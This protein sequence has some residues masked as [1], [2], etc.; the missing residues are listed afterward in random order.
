MKR[1]LFFLLM[2]CCSAYSIGDTSIVALVGNYRI[3]AEDLL[4]SYEFGPS[5]V[6]R[7]HEPLR[8]HLTYMIYERLLALEAEA[9]GLQTSSFVQERV[10]ALEEDGAVEQLYRNDILSRVALTEDQIEQDIQ[11]AKIT[12]SLRW[13]FQPTKIEAD[14]C[15]KILAQGASF[16]SL[17]ALQLDSVTSI[18]SRSTEIS[19]LKLER[20]NEIVA[21]SISG[22]RV[23]ECT[24]PIQ[25]TDGYYII[26]LDQVRQNP[27]TTESEYTNLKKQ[28]VDIRTRII[29]DK[30]A[31]EYVKTMMSKHN[32]VIKA[33][34]F[35]I[36]RAYIASKGLSRDATVKWEIPTTFMTEAGPQPIQQSGEYLNKTLVTFGNRSLTIRDYIRWY[37]IRQFQFN[38]RSLVAFNSSVK[39]TIWKM[40]QDKLLSEEAYQRGLNHVP[41]VMHETDKWRVKLLYLA[42]RSALLRTINISDSV[43]LDYYKKHDKQYKKG[44]TSSSFQQVR[45]IVLTDYFNEQESL[46][47][48]HALG[49][50]KKKYIVFINEQVLQRLSDTI[51]PEPRAIEMIFYKPG[52]TFPRVAFPT[53]DEAWSRMQ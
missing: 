45:E 24:P 15:Q 49:E 25:G 20:D 46:V 53:I 6:R 7:S 11:K 8:K 9:N 31:D 50:L 1:L 22:M 12:V 34:G 52:G 16:D 35:N 32:P 39:K 38:T 44:K 5:F 2:C 10:K 27:L 23:G 3:T 36:L 4:T 42:Q 17:F 28:A 33:E 21:H 51:R 18:S 19:L 47:L 41:S 40:V 30:L 43:L 14:E 26:R 13:L 48:L 37:D 29:A